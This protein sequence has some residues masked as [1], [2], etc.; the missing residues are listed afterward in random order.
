MLQTTSLSAFSCPEECPMKLGN[1]SGA[2][3]SKFSCNWGTFSMFYGNS[4]P[5]F[6]SKHW[7]SRVSPGF[8]WSPRHGSAPD[9]DLACVFVIPSSSVLIVVNHPETCLSLCPECQLLVQ[10][11]WPAPGAP[12]G[13]CHSTPGIRTLP[14]LGLLSGILQHMGTSPRIMDR[15]LPGSQGVTHCCALSFHI[16]P[17]AQDCLH[18]A[19]AFSVSLSFLNYLS[20]STSMALVPL[21]QYFQN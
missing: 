15:H 12:P 5:A 19:C 21:V 6:R 13:T 18:H 16:G 20:T 1:K 8:L 2:L 10:C 4:L 9:V 17:N 7:H 3:G 11:I 14:K